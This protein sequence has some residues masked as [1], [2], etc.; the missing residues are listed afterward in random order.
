LRKA[1]WYEGERVAPSGELLES[2]RR[3]LTC[4]SIFEVNTLKDLCQQ[5]KRYVLNP[6]NKVISMVSTDVEARLRFLE[7]ASETLAASAP[8]VSSFIRASKTEV[9]VSHDVEAPIPGDVCNACGQLL[10]VGWSCEVVRSGEHKQT[11][12]Q[13]IGGKTSTTNCVPC[14]ACG[15]ENVIQHHKRQK[16]DTSKLPKQV[17]E[18]EP[19]TAVPAKRPTPTILPEQTP[20]PPSLPSKESTPE[21]TQAKPAVRRKARGKNASLQALLAAKKPEAP[22]S[23]GYGLDFMDFMK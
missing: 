19:D 5:C 3:A 16:K 23:S 12:Q 18:V 7:Q 1:Q 4:S 13:R 8:T 10:L 6:L 2:P 17:T 22:K 20:V 11:R 9:A 15:T 14:S 21:V